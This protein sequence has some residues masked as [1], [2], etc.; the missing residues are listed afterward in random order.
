MR[1]ALSGAAQGRATAANARLKQMARLDLRA[2]R[3][4]LPRMADGHA[5]ERLVI[6]GATGDLAARMLLPSL[7]FL[8]ADRLL[9]PDLKI[10]GSARTQMERE[11]FVAY[12]HDVLAKRPEGLDDAAWARFAERL[13]YRAADL[14]K[15]KG[16]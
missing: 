15:A 9:P 16:M 12:V 11:K 1:A 14:T 4:H 8:D 7:Y 2:C 13:D 3:R 10:L 6:F 5:I